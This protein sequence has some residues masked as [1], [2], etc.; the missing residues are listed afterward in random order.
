MEH[1]KDI[2]QELK[3]IAPMLA[4]MKEGPNGMTLPP[5]YFDYLSESVIEQVKLLPKQKQESVEKE[6]ESWLTVLYGFRYWGSLAAILTLLITIGLKRDQVIPPAILADISSE[7][8]IIY[9]KDN[10]DEFDTDLFEREV[11]Q[12]EIVEAA[13]EDGEL[14]EYIQ[15]IIEDI[16][17]T[18]LEQLL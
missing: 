4:K 13:F 8:A 10:L 15:E 3:E 14:E 16:E 5:Y 1:K 11:L 12:T 2:Q 18:S 17:E 6:K 7:E 9:I